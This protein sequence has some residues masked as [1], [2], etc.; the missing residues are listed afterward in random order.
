MSQHEELLAAKEILNLPERA[1]MAEIKMQYRSLLRQWHPDHCHGQ[2]E[3]CAEMT[4]RILAAYQRVLA[5]CHQYQYSFSETEMRR[6]S[7]DEDWW[8]ARFGTAPIWRKPD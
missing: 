5:Y 3:E 6:Y 4:R 1:T 8:M 2:E 7:S